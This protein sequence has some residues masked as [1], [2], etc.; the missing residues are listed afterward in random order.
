VLQ[1]PLKVSGDTKTFGVTF[2]DTRV[3]TKNF[4]KSINKFRR[5]CRFCRLN[6]GGT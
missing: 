1:A 4:G 5:S 3:F 2:A 6:R